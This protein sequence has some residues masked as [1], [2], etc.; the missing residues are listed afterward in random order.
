MTNQ[1][2][3]LIL[4]AVI[5]YLLG[6]VSFSML[7]SKHLI[8]DD[9][10]RHGS[11]NPGTTNMLRTYGWKYGLATLVCDVL[12]G[13]FAALIGLWLAGPDGMFLA[14]VMVVVGH[15][16]SC[17]LR[18]R[19]GKGIAAAIGAYLVMQP[20]PSLIV[21]A[22]CLVLVFITRIMSVGTIIGMI[23]SAVVTCFISGGN[24]EWNTASIIIA[25][26]TVFAHRSN[27]QRLLRGE[28]NRLSF[29]KK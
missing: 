5:A 24:W 8:H 23:A 7:F 26:L 2:W 20:V 18:F 3:L 1:T 25:V 27:I 9:V 17:F 15:N 4:S 22:A 21:I 13:V 10:R 6:S 11:G 19:G 29:S 16:F 12:K 28:E 14:A